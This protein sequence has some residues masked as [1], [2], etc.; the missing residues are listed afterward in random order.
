MNAENEENVLVAAFDLEKVLLCPHGQTSSF[1]YCKRLTLHNF[2]VTDIVSMKK[3]MYY[4]WQEEEAEKGS[5]EMAT[6][7]QQNMDQAVKE[8]KMF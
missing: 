6:A 5:C 1:Y 3:T 4:M 7:L 8:E 2:T